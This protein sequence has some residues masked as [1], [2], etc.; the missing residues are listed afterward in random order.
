MRLL[1]KTSSGMVNCVAVLASLAIS[2]RCELGIEGD[3]YGGAYHCYH[4]I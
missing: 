1:I 4:S 3:T 2:E